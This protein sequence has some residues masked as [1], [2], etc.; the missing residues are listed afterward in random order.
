MIS[1]GSLIW[2]V[3]IIDE[4]FSDREKAFTVARDLQTS[5]LADYE[6]ID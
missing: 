4:G 2:H 6:L 1:G 3:N 5:L